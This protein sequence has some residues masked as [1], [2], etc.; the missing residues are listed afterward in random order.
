MPLGMQLVVGKSVLRRE[1]MERVRNLGAKPHGGLWSSTY[2]PQ[3]EYP[4]AWTGYLSDNMPQDLVSRAVCFRLSEEAQIACINS[5]ED[6]RRLLITFS[7]N[8]GNLDFEKMEKH[9]DGV[10]VSNEMAIRI[11]TWSVES[12]C[13]FRFEAIMFWQPIRLKNRI[14][15]LSF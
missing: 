11:P 1:K 7:T 9:L 2:T 13:L 15:D 4:S 8:E 3:A 12:L 5:E 14:S 10:Y 6:Y